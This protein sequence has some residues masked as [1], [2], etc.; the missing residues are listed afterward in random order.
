MGL[1]VIDAQIRSLGPRFANKGKIF[2]A[3]D[4]FDHLGDLEKVEVLR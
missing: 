1:R 2:Q 4:L 3:R